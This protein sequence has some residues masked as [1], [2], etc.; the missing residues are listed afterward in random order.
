[1]STSTGVDPYG[2]GG[3]VP[4]NIWTGGHYHECP[5]YLRSTSCNYLRLFMTF[6]Y[7][8]LYLCML[9]EL[10]IA[11]LCN[12]LSVCMAWYWLSV[13]LWWKQIVF[14]NWYWLLMLWHF[15]SRKRK[16]YF[17]VDQLTK[18]LQLLGTSSPGSI[19]GPCWGLPSPDSLLCP[20]NRG[21]RVYEYKLALYA[22]ITLRLSEYLFIAYRVNHR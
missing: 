14:L 19:P 12:V 11:F 1:M 17:N 5:L 6:W 9:P 2:T 13:P 8:Y 7:V 16:F 22:V 21:D 3:H 20:T 4:S 18:R 15:L 10:L